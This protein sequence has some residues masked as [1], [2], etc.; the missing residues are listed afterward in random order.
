MIKR[1]NDGNYFLVRGSTAFLGQSQEAMARGLKAASD[2]IQIA[3]RTNL[4]DM[5][6]FEE[7]I[8]LLGIEGTTMT[9]A[10]FLSRSIKERKLLTEGAGS[11]SSLLY[12]WDPKAGGVKLAG[13]EA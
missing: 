5:L 7:T 3:Q 11:G 4:A 10:T 6:Q 12:Y 1:D 8:G 2:R 9:G 13:Q